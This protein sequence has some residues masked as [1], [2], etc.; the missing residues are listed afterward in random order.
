MSYPNNEKKLGKLQTEE[1]VDYDQEED[2]ITPSIIA[3]LDP[4]MKR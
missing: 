2:I 1:K 4:S 3:G